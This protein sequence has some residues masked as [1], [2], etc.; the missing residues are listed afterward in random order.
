MNPY[1]PKLLAHGS[2]GMI[3]KGEMSAGVSEALKKYKGVYLVAVGGAAALI[4]RSIKKNTV[5]AYPELGAEAIAELIVEDFPAIV[6]QD[7]HGG[8]IYQEGVK[9]YGRS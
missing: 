5:I 9:K 8:N 4:A 6:A 7:C 2:R 3:G 1:A